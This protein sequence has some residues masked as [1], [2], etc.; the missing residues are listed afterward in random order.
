MR[1]FGLLVFGSLLVPLI[2]Q[3]QTLLIQNPHSRDHQ[4]L[5]GNWHY[6]VD[7]YDTGY[8]NHRNWQP[9]DQKES[10]KASA[11]P[12]YTNKKPENPS[13]RVECGF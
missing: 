6:V 12:Y 1:L 7:P 5:N 13:D 10:S 4:A 2:S 3:S 11:K 8:R 9:F